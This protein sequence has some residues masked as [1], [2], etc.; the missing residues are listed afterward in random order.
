MIYDAGH[1][2]V[3]MGQL[4]EN[5]SASEQRTQSST[6]FTRDVFMKYDP[7]S[8]PPLLCWE[9]AVPPQPP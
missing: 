4:C 5:E 7:P 6:T 2:P 9:Y 8:Q 3:T 1:L